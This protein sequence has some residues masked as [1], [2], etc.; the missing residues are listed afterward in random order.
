MSVEPDRQELASTKMGALS[1]GFI[2]KNLM[3]P[4]LQRNGWPRRRDWATHSL[5][6]PN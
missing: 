6:T 5:F 4:D 3:F 2:L 1:R